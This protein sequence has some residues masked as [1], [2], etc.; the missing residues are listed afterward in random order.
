MIRRGMG[1]PGSSRTQTFNA[2]FHRVFK[3]VER[4]ILGKNYPVLLSD[5]ARGIIDS[6]YRIHDGQFTLGFV[7]AKLRSKMLASLVLIKKE[8]VK[9]TLVIHVERE[10]SSGTWDNFPVSASNLD[11]I[12]SDSYDMFFYNISEYIKSPQ[13]SGI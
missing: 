6:D 4:A 9:V 7:G 1:S 10:D 8:Q 12:D 3:A 2:P 5:E 13:L 11:L